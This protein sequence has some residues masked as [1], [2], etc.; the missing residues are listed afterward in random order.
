M[1]AQLAYNHH[2]GRKTVDVSTVRAKLLKRLRIILRQHSPS[3]SLTIAFDGPAPLSKARLQ[4]RRRKTKVAGTLPQPTTEPSHTTI[5]LYS[6]VAH[7]QLPHVFIDTYAWASTPPVTLTLSTAFHLQERYQRP[8]CW[9]SASPR[10][11][12]S[13]WNFMMWRARW[14]TS[15]LSSSQRL[16]LFFPA[17]ASRCDGLTPCLHKH[18]ATECMETRPASALHLHLSSSP[19]HG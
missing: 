9:A 13:S 10:A 18:K 2:A 12:N 11:A 14:V 4:R 19:R 8:T 16:S 7:K 1:L 6:L 3:R 15:G 5:F 17:R